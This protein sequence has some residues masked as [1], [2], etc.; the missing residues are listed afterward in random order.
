MVRGQKIGVNSCECIKFLN[1]ANFHVFH[2]WGKRILSCNDTTDFSLTI[3]PFFDFTTQLFPLRLRHQTSAT[4]LR[5][6]RSSAFNRQP[7]FAVKLFLLPFTF[8]C[9]TKNIGF[10][11]S[12]YVIKPPQP[13]SAIY[14]A[15]P[16]T[17]NPLLLSML[18]ICKHRF[19]N[20]R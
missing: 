5:Y 11:D 2:V 13:S 6:L 15:P 10:N 18:V 7:P 17:G 12:G 14:G 1:I 8:H 20:V 19:C 3:F 16:F 9:S 4:K